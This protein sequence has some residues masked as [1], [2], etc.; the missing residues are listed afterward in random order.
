M[1]EH[2]G[3]RPG[4]Y[5]LE[6][7]GGAQQRY[8]AMTRREHAGCLLNSPFERLLAS[9]GF[10]ILDTAIAVL[11]K[12]QGQVAATRSAW[13]ET[14]PERVVGFVRAFL[15]A[16]AWLYDARNREEAFELF[17]AHTPNA[18]R[19]DAATAYGVLFDTQHGFPRDGAVDCDALAK[20]IE[21]RARYGVPTR[22]LGPPTAYYDSK[23]LTGA[24]AL[25]GSAAGA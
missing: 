15:A 22:T 9:Q 1:L 17:V 8:L 19:D 13:A 16:V 25:P 23:Y 21:L 12:Y 18:T 20:V 5:G 6:S 10:N 7:V 3:L 14:H 11:G 24:L 2:H 4:D